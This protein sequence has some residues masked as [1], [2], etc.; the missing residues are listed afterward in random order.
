MLQLEMK[1]IADIGLVGLPNAGKRLNAPSNPLSRAVRTAAA[2]KSTFLSAVS[3]AKPKVA[4]Y[5]FTT[6]N[7]LVGIVRFQVR[8]PIQRLYLGLPFA[9]LQRSLPSTASPRMAAP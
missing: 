8:M 3:R 4:A 6:L 2:G 5:P 1:T 7:P 9:S